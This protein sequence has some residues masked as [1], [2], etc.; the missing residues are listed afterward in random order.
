[1]SAMACVSHALEQA[2]LP[3]AQIRNICSGF[4]YVVKMLVR[5]LYFPKFLSIPGKT[6]S[7][8][9]PASGIHTF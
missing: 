4:G 8:H 5:K 7:S 2:L 1:M 9:A 3:H 6:K